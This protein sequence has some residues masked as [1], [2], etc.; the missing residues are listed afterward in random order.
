MLKLVHFK[1]IPLGPKERKSLPVKK[2]RKELAVEE[3]PPAPA[4]EALMAE[5]PGKQCPFALAWC[6]QAGG[7]RDSLLSSWI[8]WFNILNEKCS[9]ST[10]SSL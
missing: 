2:H 7:P 6:E 5:V 9:K 4:A 8:I 10:I 1:M 3:Q